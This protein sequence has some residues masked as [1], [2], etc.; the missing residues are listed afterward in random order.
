MHISYGAS[1]NPEAK[2]FTPFGPDGEILHPPR[3]H[4]NETF[5]YAYQSENRFVSYPAQATERLNRPLTLTLGSLD[6]I[7]QLIVL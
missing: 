6:D 7:S 4:F 3:I 2:Q 1:P 5:R